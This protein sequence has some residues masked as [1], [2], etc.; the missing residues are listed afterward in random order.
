M[1]AGKVK[2]LSQIV[3]VGKVGPRF[4]PQ[5][6]DPTAHALYRALDPIKLYNNERRLYFLSPLY[7][8]ILEFIWKGNCERKALKYLR[9]KKVGVAEVTL[10]HI[11]NCTTMSQ[12][13]N[14]RTEPKLTDAPLR[15]WKHLAK[16]SVYISHIS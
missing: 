6:F 16:R 10:Y 13:L 1:E 15:E 7:E 9:K 8:M 3:Q 12:S 11:V 2:S 14:C 4:E 5:L